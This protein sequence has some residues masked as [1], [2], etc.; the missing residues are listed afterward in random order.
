MGELGT[1]GA[2]WSAS[3]LQY[4]NQCRQD[5]GSAA[6]CEAAANQYMTGDGGGFLQNTAPDLIA[7]LGGLGQTGA[8]VYGQFSGGGGAFNSPMPP[9]PVRRDNTVF[10]V[11]GAVG[12][13]V[14]LFFVVKGTKK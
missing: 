4:Y 12:L 3:A 9:A 11:L 6:E 10:Y 8:N 13:L 2:G 7:F 1:G 5:G 14:V